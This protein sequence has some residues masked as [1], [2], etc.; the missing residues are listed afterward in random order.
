[1]LDSTG[2]TGSLQFTMA[3]QSQDGPGVEE[4]EL[5]NILLL[6]PHC[7]CFLHAPGDVRLLRQK[8]AQVCKVTPIR[9]CVTYVVPLLTDRPG[10]GPQLRAAQKCARASLIQ[11]AL[12]TSLGKP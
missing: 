12:Q 6:D 1:M 3:P 10:G 5:N 2:M 11:M 9:V 4:C 7:F 8:Q